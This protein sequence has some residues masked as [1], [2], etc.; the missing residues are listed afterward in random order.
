MAAV[1]QE[2]RQSRPTNDPKA[3]IKERM[4]K[5]HADLVKLRD[6][7]K[8]GE[9]SAG[10]VE[11]VKDSYAQERVDPADQ[12]SPKV[13]EVVAAENRDRS[14]LFELLAKDLKITATEVGKQNGIRNMEKASATHWLKLEGGRWVQKKDVQP[15]RK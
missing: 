4:Q 13:G 1:G 5:R 7:E 2:T 3:E 15:V 10:L 14:A 11:V 9:T 12:Q 8:V 6:G